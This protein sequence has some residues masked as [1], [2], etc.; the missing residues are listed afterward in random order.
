MKGSGNLPG[1]TEAGVLLFYSVSLQH[2]STPAV[3]LELTTPYCSCPGSSLTLLE[4]WLNVCI[5]VNAVPLWKQILTCE[6]TKSA[7]TQMLHFTSSYGI[8]QQKAGQKTMLQTAPRCSLN[9]WDSLHSCLAKKR[10]HISPSPFHLCS[11]CRLLKSWRLAPFL[12][13]HT[14]SL[15]DNSLSSSSFWP[16]IFPKPL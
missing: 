16:R 4:S 2:P 9:P 14:C 11:K 5:Y 10:T 13:N 12:S 1:P 15:S 7:E 6:Q 3:F 8:D